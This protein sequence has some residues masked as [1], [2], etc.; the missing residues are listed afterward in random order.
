[1]SESDAPPAAARK[2]SSRRAGRHPTVADVARE[3][4]V[5]P[6]TVSRVINGSASVQ[7]ETRA[8]VEEAIARIGYVPNPAAQAL[9]G[10][11]QVR[12]A[13][14]HD[15]PS[16][17]FLS[18]L[19]VGCLAQA[20]RDNAQ[21]VV[22]S[23]LGH[24]EPEALAGALARA[25]VDG[26]IL[27]PPLGDD[28]VILSALRARGIALVLVAAGDPEADIPFV[29]VD[30]FAAALDMTRHILSRGH[31][32]IGFI[33]GSPNQAASARREAGFEAGL[34]E[35]GLSP[36]SALVAQGDFSWRSGLDAAEALLAQNPPPEAI[37]ASNDDMAAA[38]ISAAH[39]RGLE[40]PRDLAVYGFDDTAVATMV[41]PGLTT[42]RQPVADMAREATDI[43][44][45]AIREA[46]AGSAPEPRQM[47]V[48]F[49]LIER[50]SG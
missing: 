1:M 20:A 44:A 13:V 24:S 47:I 27:P 39:R 5:S 48:P 35:A 6:M 8:R 29:R 33:R 49:A 21:I 43:L 25:R 38:A 50:D 45:R 41:W 23:S 16:A 26:A 46:A 37:F 2:R 9:A 15:N 31:R 11:R 18:E 17:A 30:D 14:V 32:R 4:G 42:I 40:V 19:L 28:A 12:I 3:A 34:A 7:P 22:Q 10:A 36:D